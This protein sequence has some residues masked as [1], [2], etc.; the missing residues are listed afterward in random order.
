MRTFLTRRSFALTIG[1]AFAARLLLGSRSAAADDV[2]AAGLA[3]IEVAGGGRL[4]V[5]V[6]DTQTGRRYGHRADERFPMCSTSK[7]LSC[8]ALLARVDA[9][10]DDLNRRIRYRTAD[11]VTYSPITKDHAGGDGMTLAAL[12]EAAI[13][14]SDNTA[15][16]LIL[17]SVGGPSAVTAFARAIGDAVTR[18]DRTETTLNEATPGDPRDTTTPDAMAAN[19]DALVLGARLSPS[20]RERLTGWLFGCRTGGTKLRA[21]LPAGWRIGDKTGSG[22]YGSTNDVAVIHPSGRKPLIVSAYL[23]ETKASSAMRDACIADVGR[24]VAR[25][26][27]G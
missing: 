26:A 9:G 22:G 24:A 3:R 14:V 1:A 16:N 2:L 19:L 25:L 27:Q 6:R 23:T 20:S 18:L 10:H 7:V 15:A 17:A 21:G 8:A 4:G 12:C 5:A 11:L 13:T